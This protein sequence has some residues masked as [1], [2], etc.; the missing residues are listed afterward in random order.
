MIFPLR[1]VDLLAVSLYP[2]PANKIGNENR[3]HQR[4]KQKAEG[5][6]A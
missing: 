4:M 5:A 6:P 3:M 1:F 2:S